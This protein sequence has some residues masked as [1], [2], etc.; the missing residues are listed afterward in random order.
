MNSKDYGWKQLSELPNCLNKLAY[1]GRFF[2]P[3]LQSASF[4]QLQ[5]FIVHIRNND[6]HNYEEHEEFI[7]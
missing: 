5:E 4:T 3:D 6:Q 2:V 1:F 7:I